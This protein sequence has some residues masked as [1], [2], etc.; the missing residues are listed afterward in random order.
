MSAA[1]ERSSSSFSS[2][3]L[4][5]ASSKALLTPSNALSA[6]LESWAILSRLLETESALTPFR[7]SSLV[8]SAKASADCLASPFAFSRAWARTWYIAASFFSIP[9][10]LACSIA[11]LRSETSFSASATAFV[12]SFCFS[13]RRSVFLGSNFKASLTLFK[14]FAVFLASS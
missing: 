5:W 6:A 4:R 10:S 8:T 3:A 1:L 11:L 12:K 2:R 14:E 7:S 13:I 9:A